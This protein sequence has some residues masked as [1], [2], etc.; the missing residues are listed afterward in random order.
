[1]P[2]PDQ[3]AIEQ[4]FS[5]V[6]EW[7]RKDYL[8][9]EAVTWGQGETFTRFAVG[10]VAFME[11]GNWNI[12]PAQRQIG[13]KFKYATAPLPTGPKHSG[14]FL[15]GE[16]LWMGAFTKT[17]DLAWEYMSN[18]LFTKAGLLITLTESGGVPARADMANLP[19]VT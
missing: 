11:N 12:G 5:L 7:A 10:D 19:E 2:N 8:P 13:T 1:Y 9:K 18:T 4:A 16:P 3:A 14:I 15:G 6:N 17:P